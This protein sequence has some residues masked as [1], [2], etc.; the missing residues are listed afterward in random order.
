MNEPSETATDAPL[1]DEGEIAEDAV[2]GG[3]SDA[4]PLSAPNRLTPHAFSGGA[5]AET[6]VAPKL[7]SVENGVS[8]P[9]LVDTDPAYGVV[10]KPARSRRWTKVVS[11]AI[12]NFKAIKKTTVPLGDVTILVG[13]NGSGKSSV[14]QAIHW[15]VRAASYIAPKNSKEM[16]AF[17]RI[18][19]LPSSEPLQTAHKDELKSDTKSSPSKV[20]FNHQP[21]EGDEAAATVKIFA[22]RN[23]G[24]IT[25]H[26]EGGTAVSP[27]KQREAFITAY[28]P[29]LAGL[30]ERET[31]LAQ[32]LLRRQAAS[33]D[34]GGVLRNVLFNLASRLS[35]DPDA[36]AGETR[37]ARLNALVQEVHPGV[38]IYIGFD[39]REDYYI[40]AEYKDAGLG[41]GKRSLET[42]ATGLLQ[43][44]Q[45]FA[46]I[47]L[48]RPRI[49]LV[50]EPDAH[51]HPDK[52]E[53]LIEA[54]ERAAKE[55][56]TQI[57]LTTHS[58]HIVR[59]ATPNAKQ[60]WMAEGE[61]R[62]DD[63]E[64]IRRMLGWGGLDKE[65]LL[66]V[67][68]EDDK[69][70]REILR[71]WPQI[72][73]KVSVCRCFGIDNLPKDKLL[74]GLLLGGGL[75][76]K[77]VVH[78]DRDFMTDEEVTKWGDLYKTDGVFVW[79]CAAGDVESYFCEPGYL[80]ALYGVT[81]TE[82]EEWRVKAARTVVGARDAFR[83]KR[84]VLNR[85]LWPDGG[86]PNS[87]D[88]WS[89]GGEA[90]PS[91]VVGKKLWK[92]LKSV[93]KEAGR[94]DKLLNSLA[95]PNGWKVAPDLRVVLEKACKTAGIPEPTEAGE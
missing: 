75:R 87:D 50:D 73:R 35:T 63:D 23:R 8:P 38:Q 31:I 81:D 9:P 33:G 93:I 39:A 22:A 74:D 60:V 18:D 28:I 37:L 86:S 51:L 59:A 52:Q 40:T 57:I 44:I 21:T 24:G 77:A 84:K 65:V 3:E 78:R 80:A 29:G 20:V 62:T 15:A 49:V 30:S 4:A 14:L 48:F 85:T 42:A 32:P 61:V 17:D 88:L 79:V 67:E 7:E 43:V 70:V 34:A 83:E 2:I 54:L 90:S 5:T 36:L 27:Y 92:A 58:P 95:I 68:D 56:D 69:A 66:F 25:A 12:E 45:I 10:S 47:V 6:P 11:V 55:F 71:Q 1:G 89:A 91:N 46:Y 94:D 26:I 64:A 13:P 41:Y 82:A 16:M 53:R 76:A 19:Y 72:A